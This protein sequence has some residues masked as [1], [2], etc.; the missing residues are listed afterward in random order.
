MVL[1]AKT[2]VDV[3]QVILETAEPVTVGA[4][5]LRELLQA[6]RA[7]CEPAQIS[8]AD[9]RRVIRSWGMA[10]YAGLTVAAGSADMIILNLVGHSCRHYPSFSFSGM[11]SVEVPV[12][13]FVLASRIVAVRNGDSDDDECGLRMA[14]NRGMSA[15]VFKNAPTALSRPPGERRRAGRAGYFPASRVAV[16]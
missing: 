16:M 8:D 14:F 3:E 15:W 12:D 9:M 6:E 5:L 11:V 1:N 13:L 10:S 2:H 4:F 7:L